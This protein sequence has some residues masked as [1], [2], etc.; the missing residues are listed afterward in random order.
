MK[1]K[2]CRRCS[3]YKYIEGYG[4][5]RK[6]HPKS[7]SRI[8]LVRGHISIPKQKTD[9]LV[10][11]LQDKLNITVSS[12]DDMSYHVSFKNHLDQQIIVHESGE[13][14]IQ[15]DD[16]TG[17]NAVESKLIMTCYNNAIDVQN[18]NMKQIHRVLKLPSISKQ[19]LKKAGQKI[20]QFEYVTEHKESLV[21]KNLIFYSNGR[22]LITGPKSKDA[23]IDNLSKKYAQIVRI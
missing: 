7:N 10:S 5:C 6:C 1:V 4:L 12:K 3:E 11:K 23:A 15:S 20:D 17:Y 9:T 2:Y 14:S 19:K 18:K 13:I 22:V 16:K 8:V 21:S